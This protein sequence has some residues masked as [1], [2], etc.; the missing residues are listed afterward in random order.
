MTTIFVTTDTI[1]ATDLANCV[2]AL[3]RTLLKW[4]PKWNIQATATT[5]PKVKA[6]MIIKVTDKNRHTG[7]LGYHTVEAGVPTAYCSPSAVGRTYGHVINE[8][9][10]KE[11]KVL[12]KVVKKAVLVHPAIYTQGLVTVIIHEALE[13]LADAKL[14]KTAVA[15]DG[16]NWL[17]EVCDHAA[18]YFGT[19]TVNGNVC[20]IPDATLPNYYSIG[21]VQPYDLFGNLKTPFD[22]SSPKFYAYYKDATGKFVA[23]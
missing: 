23:V 8:L 11:V 12:G 2:E 21:S 15:P 16:R 20:V 14:D 17:V 19:E 4:C 5:D 6:D 7:A 22:K 3:N 1:P 9:W 18:G 13:I 10:T